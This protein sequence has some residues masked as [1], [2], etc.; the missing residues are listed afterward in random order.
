MKYLLR[1]HSSVNEM[2]ALFAESYD[3][4]QILEEYYLKYFHNS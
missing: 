4:L 3:S 2:S 1:L